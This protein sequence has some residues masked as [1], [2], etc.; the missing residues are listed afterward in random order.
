MEKS[1]KKNWQA[2]MQA[3]LEDAQ[4]QQTDMV[5][6]LEEMKSMMAMFSQFEGEIPESVAAA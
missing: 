3:Q 4:Q 6:R 1:K 5:K 2:A